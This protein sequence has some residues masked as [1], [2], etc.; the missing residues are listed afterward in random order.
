MHNVTRYEI[1]LLRLF[2]HT[3][4]LVGIIVPTVPAQLHIPNHASP[5][6]GYHRRRDGVQQ[7]V[8]SV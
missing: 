6:F 8:V 5:L 3:L 1:D 7:N 4:N 2:M